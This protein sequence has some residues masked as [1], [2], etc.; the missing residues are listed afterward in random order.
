MI[1]DKNPVTEKILNLTLEII[2]LLTGEGYMVVKKPS[3]H[4]KD[5]SSSPHE[6]E[7]LFQPQI[8]IMNHSLNSLLHKKRNDKKIL[9]LNKDLHMPTA[10]VPVRCEDVAVYLSVEEWEYLEEHKEHYKEVM[11][12]DHHPLNSQ[13]CENEDLITKK[14]SDSDLSITD[15]EEIQEEEIHPDTSKGQ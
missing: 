6:T 10:E 14:E 7:A 5:S 4:D 8:P 2:C 13:C 3:D 15:D 9:E 1:K 12:E 11:R